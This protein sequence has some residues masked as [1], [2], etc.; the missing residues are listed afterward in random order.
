MV[1][2]WNVSG[3]V[4]PNEFKVLM[5]LADHADDS[6]VC[7]PGLAGIA[8]KA[9]IHK[10]AVSAA[11]KSLGIKGFV[12]TEHQYR[13]MVAKPQINIHYSCRKGRY[14]RPEGGVIPLPKRGVIV[15][16]KPITII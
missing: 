13:P 1:R 4:S 11:V 16:P 8:I 3:K 10:S 2:V 15:A 7:W 5:C 14:S 12:Y 6:G 9:S